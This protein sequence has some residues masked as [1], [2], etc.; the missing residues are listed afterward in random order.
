M[1]NL[2]NIN[3]KFLVTTGGNV[4]IGA[5]A[6]V[7]TVRLQVKNASAAAVLRLTGGSDS[8]DFDT[9]YTD[10]KLF[11]KSSGAAGTVMTLLGANG[12]VG[13]GTDSPSQKLVV[14]ADWNGS[15]SNNQQLQIQGNTDTTLQLR[16]GYDTTNDYAEIAAIKSG[17]GYKN[18]ILNRGGANV[19]IGETSP[20]AKLHIKGDS[21]TNSEFLII[22]DSDSTAGSIT[23]K[24]QFKSSSAVIGS[25]RAHD[26]RGLQLGGGTNT[27][28]LTIDPSGDVGIGTTNPS[29]KFQVE[30]APANGTYL[31]YLY[32]SATHNSAHG[33]NVQ[34]TTNN[35]LTYGLRVNT[36]GDSNALA[37]MGNGTVGIGTGS[38]AKKLSVNAGSTS[39]DGI[40]VTGSSS[41]AIHINE[42]SGTVNSSFQ[43]DGAG[44]YLGTT[45][46]HPLILR[47]ANTARYKITESG[48]HQWTTDGSFSTSFTYSFRD[49]VGINNPNSVSAQ[50][51]AGYVLSVGRSNDSSTSVSGGIISQGESHFVRGVSFGPS[52]QGQILD[53]YASGTWTPTVTTSQLTNP[54]ITSSSG[55]WQRVGKVVTASFEFTMSNPT[56]G[57]GGVIINNLPI[58]I[59]DTN[60][61]SG[62]GVIPALGKTINVRHYTATNQIAMNFYD[63]NYCGTAFRT[64][65]TVTYWAA[66]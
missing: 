10:N 11:I 8:W 29:S 51:V 65:G 6:D 34:T 58:A 60:H 42:T 57:G 19:G 46:S 55:R 24:I 3:N 48:S 62:C 49:A 14:Q 4:L 18:L 5:T 59:A 40:I 66:T 47:T 41:P 22:E 64:V 13:I 44:S 63:G 17:T 30:G 7:A 37:V 39:S 35:I 45:T 52:G 32:N 20:D 21:D 15:L 12:N 54:T 27:Q 33:L 56:V 28:D 38:P 50:A 26:T 53:Y 31:S 23:P 25:I 43:N 9:Y 36:G 61:V 2:S 16:L 1:A